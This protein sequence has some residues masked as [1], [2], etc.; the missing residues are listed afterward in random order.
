[1][2]DARV[3]CVEETFTTIVQLAEVLGQTPFWKAVGTL[4]LLAA[5][6][7]EVQQATLRQRLED[8]VTRF[9]IRAEVR[10]VLCSESARYREL[11]GSMG[12]R[13]LPASEQATV[14][15]ELMRTTTAH[16]G[17]C[18]ACCVSR[19]GSVLTRVH[20]QAW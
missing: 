4:R 14:L 13:R 6:E 17:M 15:N 3:M 11:G 9:R 7:N 8:T 5:A 18:A 20:A 1:M 16:T 19:G 12:L 10:V 2:S